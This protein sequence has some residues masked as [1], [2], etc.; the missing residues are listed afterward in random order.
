MTSRFLMGLLFLVAIEA[1]G[2]DVFTYKD[3]VVTIPV[4]P[5]T[6]TLIEF[7]STLQVVGKSLS[8]QVKKVVTEVNDRGQGVNIRIV[9]V[10]SSLNGAVE[11]VPF[12]LSNRRTVKIRLISQ[13]GAEK[14]HRILFPTSQSSRMI[15]PSSFIED[16]TDLMRRMLRDE[17][18]GGYSRSVMNQNLSISGYDNFDLVLVRRYQGKGLL[19]FTYKL[20]NTSDKRVVIN[21]Q[22]L[23]FGSPNRAMLLQVDHETLDPCSVNNST[24][25]NSTSCVTALRLVVRSR[26]YVAPG[27]RSDLPFTLS[28]GG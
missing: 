18:G 17:M 4:N 27:S 24:N 16:E 7:P 3:E 20:I 26:H 21:P 10:R 28:Q 11:T 12:L 13:V 8:F 9:D 5:S 1:Q 14:H 25:P 6:G 19:G 22:A 2:S 23:N 15:A